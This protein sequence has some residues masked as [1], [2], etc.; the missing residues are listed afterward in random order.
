MADKY[1]TVLETTRREFERNFDKK[2]PEFI[3][4]FEELKR[5]FTKKNIEELTANEMQLNMVELNKLKDKAKMQNT[6]NEM[7]VAKYENDIKFVRIHKRLKEAKFENIQDYELNK[8]LLEIKH[9]IDAMLVKSYKL[10]DNVPYFIGSIK[11]IIMRVAIANG[12]NIKL[13]QIDFI[14]KNILE[15]YVEERKLAS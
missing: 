2:D 3:S 12:I 6:R 11:P 9:Q 10:M 8:I 15:E 13:E 5:I 1:R 4:L 14:A 7:L